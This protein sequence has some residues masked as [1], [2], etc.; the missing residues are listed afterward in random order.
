MEIILLL[1]MLM[2]LIGAAGA[3]M[4]V[5]K[6]QRGMVK[7]FER[8]Q[9]LVTSL[10]LIAS[11]ILWK[12]LLTRDF[13]YKYVANYTSLNLPDFYAFTAFWAG[14]SGSLLFWL[15]IITVAGVLF[16]RT[17]KYRQLPEQTKTAYWMLFFF[18]EGFFLFLLTGLSQPHTALSPIPM[19]GKGLNPLLQN[20]GMAFHPPL[21]FIGY[22]LL[23]IPA[24]LSLAMAVTCGQDAWMRLT[25]GWVLPAWA[26]LSAGIILGGWWAYM[27]LGWGGY[28]AWDPVENAS[29]IP[30]FAA[31]AYLHTSILGQRYGVFKRINI[32]LINLAFLLCIVGTY[33][34]R[35]GI[36][37]SVHAFGGGGV[38]GPLLTFILTYLFLTFGGASFANVDKNRLELDII[39]RQGFVVVAVWIFLAL[40]GV[41]LLG[42][43]WPVI[44]LGWETNPV[45][46]T[47]GFYNTVTM[48]L[49]VLMGMLLLLCPWLSWTGGVVDKNRLIISTVSAL[50]LAVSGW[51]SG[52]RMLLPLMGFSAAAGFTISF[53]MLALEKRVFMSKRFWV[54]HGTH[55]GIALMIIGVAISGPY[56][57]KKEKVLAQGESLTLGGYD[58][59][60]EKLVDSMSHGVK[61]KEAVV[62]VTQN[63]KPLGTLKPAQLIFPENDHPHTEVST[64]FSL[65]KEFY[66]TIHDVKNGRLEPLIVSINPMVNWIWIGGTLVCLFPFAALLPARKQEKSRNDEAESGV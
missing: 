26:F 13:S 20:P 27:E 41:I 2:A 46:V 48:P 4:D 60:Y 52:I 66:A 23:T 62:H 65:G 58:F 53:I 19:D 25:Q 12:A 47:A 54:A 57:Q 39:S 3:C 43:M 1:A 16:F 64:I 29:I 14:R 45:G 63:G 35:S 21:L 5:W 38:G 49:F 40:G 55:L 17:K 31:T 30:W 22:G 9:L 10:V 28:W 11:G 8:G 50:A 51:V 18:V 15:L 34:V 6:G 59:T 36:I 37:E 33:I 61:S 32:I 24:C 56:Q 7:W 44:S 42:T